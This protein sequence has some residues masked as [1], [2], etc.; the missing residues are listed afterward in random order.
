MLAQA[1]EAIPAPG[2]MAGGLAFEQKFDGRRAIL[3]HF[4]RAGRAV[5][6]PPTLRR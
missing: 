6:L 4:G 1:A 2:V 3:F 5:L